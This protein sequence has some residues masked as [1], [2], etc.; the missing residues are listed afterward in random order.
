M[1]TLLKTVAEKY[2]DYD[3]NNIQ[4]HD[5]DDMED[6]ITT[7]SNEAGETK[8]ENDHANG[9]E[10]EGPSLFHQAEVYMPHGENQEIAKVIGRKRN[11]D[12]TYVGK[13]HENPTL[14]T[15]VFT[16]RFPD[17]DEKD[18]AYNVIAEHLYSQ[19][20][21]HGNQYHIYKDIM[22]TFENTKSHNT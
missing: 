14:D 21:E 8:E 1:D 7:E 5:N 13:A 18:V 12:R 3:P 19:V 4:V 16:V 11:L 9:D 10:L 17:G 20:D 2:T 6:P 15:R 22:G